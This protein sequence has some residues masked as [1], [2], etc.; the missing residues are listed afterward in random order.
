MTDL[1]TVKAAG[2]TSAVVGEFKR[3]QDRFGVQTLVDDAD[4]LIRWLPGT[5]SAVVL[6]FTGAALAMGAIQT[7]EF[8]T[9]SSRNARNHVLFIS[10]VQNTYYSKAA[11]RAR[12]IG[13]VKAFIR[14]HCIKTASAIGNSMGGF[15][16]ILFSDH[17]PM[18]TVLAFSPAITLED[19]IV[20]EPEWLSFV[21]RLSPERVRHLGP[22]MRRRPIDYFLFF[23]DQGV[24]D[25][26]HLAAVPDLPHVTTTI[27][28]GQDHTVSRWIK[29][30]GAMGVLINA[31][32]DADR[33]AVAS[34]CN[35]L[36]GA[37]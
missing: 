24:D 16:A 18:D 36:H 25:L 22:I 2:Q 13:F 1:Q 6:A 26:R 19:S 12:V 10:D 34:I 5:E 9:G 3:S 28:A 8:R 35:Q 20:T 21:S 29:A 17:V 15:G 4:L 32:L 27:F 37:E 30:R 11:L 7:D 14:D 33:S 31:C 23:G